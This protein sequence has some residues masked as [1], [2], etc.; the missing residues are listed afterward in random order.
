MKMNKGKFSSFYFLFK[1]IKKIPP[2]TPTL[3]DTSPTLWPHSVVVIKD[4]HS[5]TIKVQR[6]NAHM[7]QN[8]FIY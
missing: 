8:L 6:V 4:I 7:W 5:N 2:D 1:I 3:V